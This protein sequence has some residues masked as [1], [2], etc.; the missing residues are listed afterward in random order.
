MEIIAKRIEKLL[1][2]KT[3]LWCL[4]FLGAF[5]KLLLIP[6]CPD[7][8]DFD[9][10]INPWIEFI[11]NNGYFK[12][13]EHNF[14]NYTPMYIYFLTIIAKSGF[15]S[16]F[17]VK[18]LSIFFEYVTA[19]FIGKF[20][21]EKTGKKHLMTAA[22][23]IFP[24]LPTV[25]INSSYSAQCDSIYTCFV[26]GSLF[27]LFRK[28][29]FLSFLFLGIAFSF[30]LQTVFVFPFYFLLLLKNQVKWYYFLLIPLTYFFSIL[31]AWILGR[32]LSELLTIYLNQANN[33][34]LL[35]MNLPNLYV[36]LSNDYYELIKNIGLVVTVIVSLVGAFLLRKKRLNLESMVKLVFLCAVLFPFILPGMHERYLFVGETLAVVY[37]LLFFKKIYIPIGIFTISFIS[38][39]LC[40]RFHDYIPTHLLSIFYLFIISCLIK[41]FLHDIRTD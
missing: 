20:L 38:Y 39:L 6:R 5:I 37:F 24:L 23:A 1:Q 41:D 2:T 32:P 10:F 26:I 34:K 13:L 16:L 25:L 11:K 28:K 29:Q 27:F 3:I 40:S 15:N 12:A 8:R 22:F 9:H 18:I 7:M 30:K 36:W 4:I 21:V 17:S 33:Y 35:T 19:Y 14:Y 31:P